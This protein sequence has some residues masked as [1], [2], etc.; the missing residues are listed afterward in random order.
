VGDPAFISGAK[1][2]SFIDQRLRT[3]D[4]FGPSSTRKEIHQGNQRKKEVEVGN[5]SCSGIK[6]EHVGWG[7]TQ[8][9]TT[10]KREIVTSKD[11]S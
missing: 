10:G 6:Q 2:I 8:K 5:T 9:T 1:K 7:L 11:I 4:V 3:K